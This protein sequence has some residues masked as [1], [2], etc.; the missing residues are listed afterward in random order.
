[1]RNIE[2]S[3]PRKEDIEIINDFFKRV[4]QHTFERNGIGDLLETIEGEIRYKR[5][6]LNQDFESEGR[7]RYFLV[8]KDEEKIVGSIEYGPSNELIHKCTNGEFKDLLEI[9]TVFVDPDYQNQGLG[10]RLLS[11]IFT[12]FEYKGVKEFCFDSG[13]PSAQQVWIKKFGKPAYHIK[14]FWGEGG[15]HMVWRIELKDALTR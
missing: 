14:D 3:R 12:E 11:S 7:D 6:I 1:M 2:I 4:I 15:D 8:A 5:V 9:G 13:Y 10:S